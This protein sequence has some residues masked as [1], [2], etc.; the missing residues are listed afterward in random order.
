MKFARYTGRTLYPGRR[1]EDTSEHWSRLKQP[2]EFFTKLEDR[3]ALDPATRDL[4]AELR[5]RG[6]WPSKPS[7][8]PDK[9]DGVSAWLGKGKWKDS[10]GNWVK[11]INRELFHSALADHTEGEAKRLA[12]HEEIKKTQKALTVS[13]YELHALTAK[14]LGIEA[15]KIENPRLFGQKEY[16]DGLKIAASEELI[17]GP[18]RYQIEQPEPAEVAKKDSPS[19]NRY[20]L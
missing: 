15:G 14:K 4:I 13:R 9:E 2:I 11:A 17:N 10:Q 6:K 12:E 18:T 20:A 16:T 5:R 8:S 19:L 3:A 1:R 7:S